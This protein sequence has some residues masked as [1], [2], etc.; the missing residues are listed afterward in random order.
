[1]EP[2]LQCTWLEG[3]QAVVEA[4][5]DASKACSASPLKVLTARSSST[6]QVPLATNARAHTLVYCGSGFGVLLQSTHGC[7]ALSQL[8]PPAS[9]KTLQQHRHNKA[10]KPAVQV[11]SR[12]LSLAGGSPRACRNCQVM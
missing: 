2:G 1:M 11:S 3:T 5:N 6:A 8:T 12:R 4:W 10:A 9:S 7:S